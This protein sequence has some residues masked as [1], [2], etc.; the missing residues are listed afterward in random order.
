MTFFI[1]QNTCILI[2]K[3]IVSITVIF[4]PIKMNFNIAYVFLIAIFAS[5]GLFFQKVE[6]KINYNLID[7][8]PELR[9]NWENIKIDAK[10]IATKIKRFSKNFIF[11]TAT[12]AHQVEGDNHNNWSEFEKLP[13]KI[14]NGDKSGKACEHY[15]RYKDDIQLMK[16]QL[17]VRS[18]RFV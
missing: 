10:E 3:I 16:N 12:A 18:Y 5:L 13:G 2:Y 4:N 9:W 7:E 1:K 17:G 11:G 6:L 14:R 8:D 15:T